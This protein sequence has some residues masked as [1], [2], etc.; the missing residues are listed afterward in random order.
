MSKLYDPITN[1]EL[2]LY[3]QEQDSHFCY[4]CDETRAIHCISMGLQLSENEVIRQLQNSDI[5]N[6]VKFNDEIFWTE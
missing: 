4:E 2:T 6:P 1:E 3:T 5:D